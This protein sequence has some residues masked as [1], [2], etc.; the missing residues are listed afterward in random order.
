M[1]KLLGLLT[2]VVGM[3]SS[4]T[5]AT[6]TSDCKEVN[7]NGGSV[8]I[9]VE[10]L[11]STRYQLHTDIIQGSASSLQC[12]IL[13]VDQSYQNIGCDGQFYNNNDE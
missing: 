6:T 7:F 4:L 3:A 5:F 11:S 9:S 1:K 2:L 12:G 10:K 13:L 8:C